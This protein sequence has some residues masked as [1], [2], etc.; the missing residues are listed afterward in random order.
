M[1]PKTNELVCELEECAQMLRSC[2]ET[3]W[4]TWLEKSIALIK[5]GNFRGIEHF[6][7]AFGGMGSINDFI[8]HPING[9][10][11]DEIDAE[12]YNEK[13]KKHFKNAHEL[14]KVIR[15]NVVFEK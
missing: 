9:H 15:N 3:H 8:I 1:G 5:Q 10:S 11:I 7:G 2:S 14:I 4:A 6:E 12:R 13:M